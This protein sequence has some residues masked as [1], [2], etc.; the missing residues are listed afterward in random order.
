MTITV[1]ETFDWS[2]PANYV[3][4]TQLDGMLTVPFTPTR[5]GD[6]TFTIPGPLPF[7]PVLDGSAEPPHVL[8]GPPDTW[9]YPVLITAVKPNGMASTTMQAVGYDARVYA[10]DDNS[11]P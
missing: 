1:S 6:K 11:P 2:A 7:T 8:F 9:A 10:D 4:F 5:T 3:A